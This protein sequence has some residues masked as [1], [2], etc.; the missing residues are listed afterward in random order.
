MKPLSI[1]VIPARNEQDRIANCIDALA[2][3]TVTV[4]AFEVILVA[5]ACEDL[6]EAVA[7]TRAAELGIRLT[8]LHGPG[9]G[10][11]PARRLGMDAAAER[12]ETL[13][14]PGGL[15]A[16]TDADTTPA[17]D[18]LER[19]LAHLARGAEAIG[20]MIELDPSDVKGLPL[21]V[22]RRREADA[23][24]RLR[25]VRKSDP[26]AA[27]HHF[28]G[29]SLG[30]NAQTY[31]RVGGLD[32]SPALEDE[33][34]AERL[35]RHHVPVLRPAD[36]RV[37]TAART[38]GR[39]QRGLSV[40][41]AVSSWLARRRYR[42]AQF[43]VGL[44]KELKRS[45]TV[46]VVVPT[47]NCAATIE[48]VLDGTVGPARLAGLVDEVVVIDGSTDGT[49]A[50]AATAGA[51]VLP[52]DEILREFGPSQGKGD[53]MWRALS[54]TTGSV[55]CF[56]DGDTE[57]ADPAHLL[58]LLGPLFV[59]PAIMLVKGSFARPLRAGES[60]LANEGGRVTELAA[61]PLLNLH[62][63]LLA[64]FQQ[65]LAG[66]F[67]ARRALLEELSFPS[68]Y[69]V[70]IA[71]LID[72][73]RRHGLDAL[74]ESDLGTR[75]NRHQPLRALGEMAFAVMVAVERRLE[76]RSSSSS[77]QYLR[78]WDDASTVRV[79]VGERPPLATLRV[80]L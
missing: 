31:R 20:G 12:L 11:G 23:Q 80:A 26:D 44:L 41:L 16:T 8:V 34:F 25:T 74:A 43:D 22:R 68:G 76:G 6:T 49:R 36:V 59:D 4:A 28:A 35:G 62:F 45:T 52:E 50:R 42:A 17:T 58:G 69:G 47:K 40:D 32:P 72:S 2:A 63:P 78:P 7:R 39:A 18:W 15:I 5:D 27:H 65:P 51:V 24:R 10:T 73:L 21:E 53:A 54:Q 66:E 38:Q 60:T 29:A 19:Q 55:V 48:R 77:G 1:V 14:L 70:E 57:D 56:L 75:Q 79:P 30:I 67:G 13:G 33:F 64:G 71:V 37:R 3:Q 61:R 46:S 9:A